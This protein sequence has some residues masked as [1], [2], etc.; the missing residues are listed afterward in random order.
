SAADA[1]ARFRAAVTAVEGEL[2]A[3][4]LVPLALGELTSALSLLAELAAEVEA[5]SSADGA[6]VNSLSRALGWRARKRVKRALDG[7]APDEIAAIDFAAWR[8]SLRALASA[9]VVDRGQ[10]SLRDALIAWIQSDDPE[11][12]SSLPP[13][14]DLRARVGAQP[15]ARELLGI[16]VGA[17]AATL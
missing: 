1:A 15:E 9:V 14:A 16:A 5:V 6:L 4:C 17:W 12:A 13:E 8:R 10:S 2:S 3:P 7:H 11:G